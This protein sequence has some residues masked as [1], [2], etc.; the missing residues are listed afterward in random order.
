MAL[1]FKRQFASIFGWSGIEGESYSDKSDFARAS[2]ARIKVTDRHGRVRNSVSDRIY[3]V[4]SGS[5]WFNIEGEQ[6][7][8]E[9][10]D[11]IIVPRMCVYDYGGQLELFLVHAPAYQRENDEDFEQKQ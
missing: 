4:L 9:V 1:H 11:V 6:I 5:G 2:V 10:D 8:V 7:N 3:L